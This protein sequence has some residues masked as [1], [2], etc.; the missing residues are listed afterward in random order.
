M[1]HFVPCRLSDALTVTL[2]PAAQLLADP[3]PTSRGGVSPA[4]SRAS[5]TP[6][7]F[8]AASEMGV[9]VT[10]LTSDDKC[11]R[12]RALAPPQRHPGGMLPGSHRCR[13]CRRRCKRAEMCWTMRWQCGAPCARTRCWPTTWAQT[14]WQQRRAA[15]RRGGRQHWRWRRCRRPW[16]AAHARWRRCASRL[17][18]VRIACWLQQ[19]RLLT[20]PGGASVRSGGR[21]QP[22]SCRAAAGGLA[23]HADGA[24]RAAAPSR[25]RGAGGSPCCRAA[26]QGAGGA[27][28]RRVSFA[29]HH[30]LMHSGCG[31]RRCSATPR[32][33]PGRR[34]MGASGKRWRPHQ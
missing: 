34:G 27:L 11:V 8:R 26:A 17:S 13:R 24:E 14:V 30:R 10:S 31:R 6:F 32:C 23:G 21:L 33:G 25:A 28:A 5:D 4:L 22:L 18:S 15:W 9:G 3:V 1:R 19:S 2:S 7:V 12:A 20:A 29:V 16:R